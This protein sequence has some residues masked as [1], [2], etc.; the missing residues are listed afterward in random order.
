MKSIKSF[1]RSI[2]FFAV[3]LSF[4]YKGRNYYAT[5]LGGLFIILLV[6]VVLVIGIYYFIPFVNRK[7]LLYIITQ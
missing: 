1:L 6:I 3:P 5:S 4:R 7:N 2:D